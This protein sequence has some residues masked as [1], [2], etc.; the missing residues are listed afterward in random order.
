ML[1]LPYEDS[2][3]SF[4]FSHHTVFHMLKVDIKRAIDEMRRVLVPGGLLFVNFPP[5][6]K[7]YIP[8]KFWEFCSIWV[9]TVG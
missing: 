8:K 3:F 5:T 7:N 4:V 1:E 9:A 2:S 6:N